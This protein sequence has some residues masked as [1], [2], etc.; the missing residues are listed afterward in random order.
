[1]KVSFIHICDYATVSREG[2]LSIMGIFDRIFAQ[3]FPAVHAMLYLA[4]EIELI[5][6]ELGRQFQIEIHLTDADGGKLLTANAEMQVDPALAKA[7][8]TVHLPQVLQFA[9]VQLPKAGRYSF[10]VF[11][12]GDHKKERA[13]DVGP[14]EAPAG[15][16][17][18][19]GLRK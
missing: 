17:E 4:F 19:R 6:A 3:S 14:L 16:G 12:N 5:P 2:K 7:G 9:G 15:G 8:D 18:P 11:L 13:F 10:H 1:M